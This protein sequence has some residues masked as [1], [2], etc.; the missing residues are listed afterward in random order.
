MRLPI[1][2]QQ[3]PKP[4]LAPFSHNTS[5]MNDGRRTTIRAIDPYTIAVYNASKSILTNKIGVIVS[6]SRVTIVCQ[7]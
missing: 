1:K 6:T 7:F 5:V 4:Y 3:Q 2:D